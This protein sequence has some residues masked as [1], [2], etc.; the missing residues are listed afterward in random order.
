MAKSEGIYW[1]N[2]ARLVVPSIMQL[3]ASE[4][5][6]EGPGSGATLT[7]LKRSVPVATSDQG[8]GAC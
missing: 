4:V 7:C 5:S 3:G 2:R 6:G 1:V 8:T